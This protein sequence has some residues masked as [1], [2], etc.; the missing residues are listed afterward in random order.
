MPNNT[1]MT[2][3]KIAAWPKTHAYRQGTE[4]SLWTHPEGLVIEGING[5]WNADFQC[6]ALP[7]TPMTNSEHA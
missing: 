1:C 6:A 3:M 5:A 2:V 4:Y 7:S